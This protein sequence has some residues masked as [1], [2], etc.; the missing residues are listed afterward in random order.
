MVLQ[1][2]P[3]VFEVSNSLFRKELYLFASENFP[4]ELGSVSLQ[5][6]TES[7]EGLHSQTEFQLCHSP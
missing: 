1:N 2:S 6:A 3:S 7:G 5:E 4:G